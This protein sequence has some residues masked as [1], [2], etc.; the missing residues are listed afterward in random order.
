MSQINVNVIAPVG[1]TGTQ[2]GIN[3]YVQIVDDNGGTVS[4]ISPS[5]NYIAMGGNNSTVVNGCIKIGNN[6]GVSI[7][8]NVNGGLSCR[9]KFK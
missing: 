9:S 5:D 8:A 2:V 4:L 3:N 6:A 1:Y 7:S